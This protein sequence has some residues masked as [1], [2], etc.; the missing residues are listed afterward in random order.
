MTDEKGL[1]QFT[2]EWKEAAPPSQADILELQHWRQE[3]FRLG[4]IGVYDYGVSYGNISE[5]RYKTNS[6]LITGSQTGYLAEL[7][8]AQYTEVTYF[9]LR[10]NSLTCVGPIRA[11]SE[12]LTHAALYL[13]S[14]D[15]QGVIHF[16][17]PSLWENLRQKVPTT[18]E[19]AEAGTLEIALDI[20]R[21][22]ETNGAMSTKL[23]VMGGH[24]NGL[25]AFGGSLREAGMVIIKLVE[26][27]GT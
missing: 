12:S 21:L 17:H 1:I 8:A 26:S 22:I 11:S 20:E 15:I 13:S 9:D 4:V 10:Q 16:H 23:F 14:A 6:F 27:G 24:K 18:N 7:T 2:C 25:L 19:N 5:R 3:C